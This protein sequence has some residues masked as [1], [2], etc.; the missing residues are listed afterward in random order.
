VKIEVFIPYFDHE[1]YILDTVSSVKIPKDKNWE[2]SV[3][4]MNDGSDYKKLLNKIGTKKFELNVE[5]YDSPNIGA[6]AQHLKA[7]KE[8]KADILFF[9]NSDDTFH[10]NRIE[11]FVKALENQN[12]AWAYSDVNVLNK[13]PNMINHENYVNE[14]LTSQR[15]SKSTNSLF[16]HNHIVSTGNLVFKNPSH[17]ANVFSHFK[18]DNVHD[19]Y[20]ARNLAMIENPVYIP[21]ILYNYFIH[22]SN[23]FSK[24]LIESHVEANVLHF[25]EQ[26]VIALGYFGLTNDY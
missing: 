11:Y 19:W 22:Y 14:I 10:E 24:N 1:E 8:S 17:Y 21:L 13:N 2:V 4:I 12:N 26:Q 5:V 18:L 15:D 9:L 23:T 20:M 7:I 3:K 6:F 16:N 25:V